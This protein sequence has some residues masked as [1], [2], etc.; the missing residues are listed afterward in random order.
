MQADYY[1]TIEDFCTNYN[2]EPS[3]INSL[4]ENG[5][6]EI[7]NVNEPGL[8]N[9]DQLRELEK[10]I[11]LFYDLDI[12]LEG[13]ETINHLLERIKSMNLEIIALRNRLR[14]YE[15]NEKYI[16]HINKTRK[17]ENSH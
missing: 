7:E 2:V 5:L 14:L 17:D 11:S 10:I 12:N 8:I 3:F 16:Y 13:I 1:I 4:Q 15:A 6:I 9:A